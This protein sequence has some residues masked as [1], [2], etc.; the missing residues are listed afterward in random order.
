MAL[1]GKAVQDLPIGTAYAVWTGIGAVRT[2]VAQESSCSTTGDGRSPLFISVI[3]FRNRR[4]PPASSPAATGALGDQPST[5]RTDVAPPAPDLYNRLTFSEPAN[6]CKTRITGLDS[7]YRLRCLQDTFSTG[8]SWTHLDNRGRQALARLVRQRD[9]AGSP[10]SDHRASGPPPSTRNIGSPGINWDGTRGG[11]SSGTAAATTPR[12]S[13]TPTSAGAGAS[14]DRRRAS[15]KNGVDRA[16]RAA[17]GKTI[18]ADSSDTEN[19][20]TGRLK[21][22]RNGDQSWPSSSAVQPC[23]SSCGHKPQQ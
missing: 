10:A 21:R 16:I 20:D 18:S 2:R 17:I 14:R 23:H 1:L 4:A 22:H 15:L 6:R 3:V 12:P 11:R 8:E 19:Q 5:G 7:D 9:G 13:C